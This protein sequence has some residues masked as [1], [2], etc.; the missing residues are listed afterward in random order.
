MRSAFGLQN[1]KCSAT[2]RGSTCTARWPL[3]SWR[4]C[5]SGRAPSAHGRRHRARRVVRPGDQRAGG[6]ALSGACGR[7]GQPAEGESSHGGDAAHGAGC[8]TGATS[9]PRRSLELPLESSP[10]PRGALRRRS[11]PSARSGDSIEALAETNRAEY[12][13]TAG[14]FSGKPAEIERFFDEVEAGVCYVNKRSGATTGA[15]P[16]AQPFCGWKGSA[17]R[18]ERAAAGPST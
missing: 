9:S 6:R 11:S 13:L 1:Q 15:W 8:S 7:A 16:G 10:L 12:G 3:R 17:A 2:S 14:I 5:W 4:S 18:A